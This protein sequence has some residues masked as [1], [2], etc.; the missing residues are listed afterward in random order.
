MKGMA[1]I[2]TLTL[3]ITSQGFA[4]RVRLPGKIVDEQCISLEEQFKNQ[5]FKK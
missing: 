1:F 5:T 4:Q 3:A 2:V